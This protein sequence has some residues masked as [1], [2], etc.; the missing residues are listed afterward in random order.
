MTNKILVGTLSNGLVL[1]PRVSIPFGV[2][3]KQP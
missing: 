2:D 3:S 1:I